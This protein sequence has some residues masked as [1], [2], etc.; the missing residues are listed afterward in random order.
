MA[1]KIR[2]YKE[3]GKWY[4][5]VPTMSKE[6]NEMVFGADIFLETISKG[7]STLMIEF[8]IFN[9]ENAIYSFNMIEHD[10]YGATYQNKDN[11]DEKIWLCNVVHEVC[12]EHP[13]EIFI[14]SV[15]LPLGYCYYEGRV[16]KNIESGRLYTIVGEGLMKMEDGL[17]YDSVTY[18]GENWRLVNK[19]VTLFTKKKS[20]FNKEFILM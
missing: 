6:D 18:R 9:D 19:P 2:F 13:G 7:N 16:C 15:T 10:E 11:K 12:I 5:D 17:W 3:N 20:D 1:Y 14:T 8:S 4:A